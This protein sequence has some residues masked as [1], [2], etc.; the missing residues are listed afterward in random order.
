MADPDEPDDLPSIVSSS[1]QLGG[2]PAIDDAIRPTTIRHQVDEIIVDGELRQRYNYIEYEFEK[3]G[4]YCRARSYVD[5]I[6]EAA[7]FGP[8]AG[9]NDLRPVSASNFRDDVLD[10][11]KRRFDHIT[12]L[13]DVGYVSI[14]SRSG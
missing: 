1:I 3:D 13:G 8:F 4:A 11:L 14:W 9:K 6:G 2:G 7:I 5:Q 12:E 10:Y